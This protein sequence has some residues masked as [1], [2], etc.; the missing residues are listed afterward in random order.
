[1][2]AKLN[3]RKVKYFALIIGMTYLFSLILFC[4]FLFPKLDRIM[5]CLTLTKVFIICLPI[6]SS[7]KI[8]EATFYI[9]MINFATMFLESHISIYFTI[10]LAIAH[11]MFQFESVD[12]LI[13]IGEEVQSDSSDEELQENLI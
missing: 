4:S 9:I 7:S 6:L 1:M 3:Q 12:Y 5:L 13:D 2:F 10:M 11:A 8:L